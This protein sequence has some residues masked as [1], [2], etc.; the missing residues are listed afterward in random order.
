MALAT[1]DPDSASE[2][3]PSGATGLPWL[4]GRTRQLCCGPRAP[5][6]LCPAPRPGSLLL[7]PSAEPAAWPASF[8][9]LSRFPAQRK[10]QQ[11]CEL[12]ALCRGHAGVTCA[13]PRRAVSKRNMKAEP[14]PSKPGQTLRC[15]RL[16]GQ[17]Q[18][19][20]GPA[21]SP[22]GLTR[23]RQP[24]WTRFV[25]PPHGPAPPA[26]PG[27]AVPP[28]RPA[29]AVRSSAAISDC[30]SRTS[31]HTASGTEQQGTKE[32]RGASLQGPPQPR[33]P[34]TRLGPPCSPG[35]TRP[36]HSDPVPEPTLNPPHPCPRPWSCPHSAQCW[37]A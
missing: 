10:Q 29:L 26:P 21:P 37:P 20:A 27:P 25:V 18:C 31:S 7:R 17:H 33:H 32:E 11:M 5:R 12:F 4:G 35:D 6:R 8:P 16:P 1:T 3:L 23:A 22:T 2:P 34:C 13:Q 36:L 9:I 15:C 28:A 19:G 14:R 30:I 24:R